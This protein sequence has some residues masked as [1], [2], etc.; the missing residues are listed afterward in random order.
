MQI[1]G[2]RSLKT[3]KTLLLFQV[4]SRKN[5]IRDFYASNGSAGAVMNCD[6]LAM[7]CALYPSFIRNTI[8]CHGSC[9][10]EPGETWG[11]V[12]FYQK[13]F[14]FDAVS[15]DFDY[16]VTLITDVDR[17][18]FFSNYLSAIR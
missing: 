4:V 6:A 17:E 1:Y 3:A 18:R 5:W 14:T 8:Q 11:E 16:N 9:I 10:I 7:T 15:N 12:L 13:G 2:L